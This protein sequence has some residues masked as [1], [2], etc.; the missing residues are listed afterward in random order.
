MFVR[1]AKKRKI[2]ASHLT[3]AVKTQAIFLPFVTYN[4][5]N[6]YRLF[7]LCEKFYKN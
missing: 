6:Y 4:A 5:Q 1:G 2:F 3:A 7:A